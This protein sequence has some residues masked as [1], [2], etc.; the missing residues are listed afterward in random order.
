MDSTCRAR[1]WVHTGVFGSRP[2]SGWVGSSKK[3]STLPMPASMKMCMY[4]SASP[5]E[6]TASS[7]I[8]STSFMPRFC[9]YQRAVSRASLQR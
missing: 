2:I 3:A 7:A 1:C 4:G 8:A 6:G 5:V 9:S